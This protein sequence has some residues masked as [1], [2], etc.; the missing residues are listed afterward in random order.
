MHLERTDQRPA[1]RDDPRDELQSLL[2]RLRWRLGLERLALFAVQGAIAGSLA[3]IALTVGAW[4]T[5]RDPIIVW[6]GVA[7]LLAAVGLAVVRW[8]SEHDAAAAA[9]HHM[10]LEERLATAAELEV[11]V[12]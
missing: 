12:A 7:P 10:R 5:G 6:L 11:H 3:L 4:I 2:A 1:L 8:P 9:D